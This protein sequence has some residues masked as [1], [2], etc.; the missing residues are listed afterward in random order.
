MNFGYQEVCLEHEPGPRHPERPGRLR[1]I[2]RTL[3]D[4]H[5]VSY[6]TP[7]SGTREELL[8]VHDAEYVDAVESFVA[9]GGGSWGA[10]TVASDATWTAAL[11]S[12]GLARWAASTALDGATGAATPFALGR[13]PGHHALADDAMG[14]CFFNNTAVATEHA[15]RAGASRVAVIDWDVHHGN[16][17]QKLFYDRDDVFYA[18]VHEANLYPNT[19]EVDETGVGSGAGTTLN[20]PL[21][22]TAGGPAVVTALKEL[23]G[24]AVVAFDPDAVLVSAGFDGHRDDPISQLQVST[25]DYARLAAAVE[26]L[27]AD[28]GA[29]LGFILEGGYKLDALAASV[30]TVQEVFAG[31]EP[32]PTDA[33]PSAAARRVLHRVDEH[34]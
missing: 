12:A 14:F 17:T 16:G 8:A 21:P 11:A 5:Q 33:T 4:R 30:R 29:G 2:R 28:A 20:I 3:A 10:D 27:A 24:P 34:H 22:P 15:R 1:R 6:T 18:S 13:P 32:S 31:Y 23:I 26:T 9:N 25:E 7:A 19:G